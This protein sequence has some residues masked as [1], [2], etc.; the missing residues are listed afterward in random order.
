V[1]S[2]EKQL[3]IEGDCGSIAE[4]AFSPD[5][6]T[7]LTACDDG[8]PKMRDGK[9]GNELFM[10]IGHHPG[11]EFTSTVFGVDISSD[12]AFLASAGWDSTAI[13]WDGA[14]RQKLV[15]LEGH[16]DRVNS[17]D[18][19]PDDQYLAT[20]SW[21]GTVRIW[22]VPGGK[23]IAILSGHSGIIWVVKFSPDGKYL[24]T[25]SFDATAKIWNASTGE[26]VLTLTGAP[27][28]LGGLAFSPDGRYLAVAGG[29]GIIRIYILNIEELVDVAQS[30]L[31][32]ALTEAEC[33]QFLHLETCPDLP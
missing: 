28:G 1:K 23:E 14:T 24:A 19:S 30:R 16:F 8:V 2:G 15:T 7:I 29:D 10:L 26:E 5:G 9:T 25:S 17:V 3:L 4:V 27:G 18:F 13:L 6:S 20:A 33:Q 11:T 12:D 32:R 22:E 31:T 21:D